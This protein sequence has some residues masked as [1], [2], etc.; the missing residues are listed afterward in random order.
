MSETEPP[1]KSPATESAALGPSPIDAAVDG[2]VADHFRDS[3]LS[4]DTAAWNLLMSAIPD[5]KRRL[6]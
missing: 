5:L 6:V 3:V 2:W 4:R 1:P